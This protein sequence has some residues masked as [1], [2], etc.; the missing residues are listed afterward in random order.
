MTINKRI[1]L[2]RALMKEKGVDAYIIPSSDAH[3]SEY[4]PDYYKGR[5]WITGFSGSAGT[6]VITENH[7]GLWT[8]S[9]YYL[10][11]EHQLSESEVKLHKLSSDASSNHIHWLANNLKE[12]S[13]VGFDPRTLTVQDLSLL[14]KHLP[15]G[16]E[17]YTK[18]D[19]LDGIWDERPRLPSA[20]A[21]EITNTGV[22]RKEK[23]EQLKSFLMTNK[24]DYLIIPTLDDIAW[25]FNIRGND[26]E[27]NPVSMA[28][29]V[30]GEDYTHLF[31]D[32]IKLKPLL[33]DRLLNDGIHLHDYNDISVFI[34]EIGTDKKV[35]YDP[36]LTSVYL[37]SKIG[38]PTTTTTLPTR[39][40]KAIKTETELQ[41]V[42]N[43]MIK[44]GVALTKA[45]MWLE[46]TLEER[47][48]SE[49][50]FS[51][52]IA[53]CRALQKGYVGES[54]NAIVGY[55][56]NGAIVHYSPTPEG[57]AQIEKNGILLCDSGGQYLDGTTDITR[58]VHLSP[59]PVDIKKHY[60]LVLKGHI[61]LAKAIF[62]EGTRGI[63]LDVEARRHLWKHGLNYGH[64]TGH[65]V[66]FFLNV[67]ES[68]Q[69]FS[70]NLDER[71]STILEPGMLSS[72]EPGLYIENEYGIRI[73]NLI[74]CQ[75]S[76]EF[77]SYLEH[78]TITLFPIDS[79]LIYT[80]WMTMEE[81]KWLNAYHRK[82]KRTLIPYLNEE[83]KLWMEEKCAPIEIHE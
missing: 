41:Q 36:R 78:K 73:E 20:E 83:E 35:L 3:Q 29:A 39:H 31:I 28:Y 18:Y 45:F 32:Q 33:A 23:I 14:K 11:A 16:S 24:A 66:G 55:K 8:D 49:Y 68:P 65:G 5:E 70:S 9:R 58:T 26:V 30:A 51:N 57:S 64:G 63:Q 62:P 76:E 1:E 19:L 60:T 17:F 48:V 38:A 37:H 72:N 80:D 2:L 50:E 42:D 22:S 52:K 44:D 56:G 77:P 34:Q 43:A 47:S 12:G 40:W 46:K 69:G 21:Y 27:F 4:V 79:E 6:A 82:V 61:G 15:K 81:L 13:V 75:K 71:G 59:T 74:V 53:E 25:V 10:Q 67:H 54:F 7:A